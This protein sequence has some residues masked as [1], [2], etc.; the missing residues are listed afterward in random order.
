MTT[1]EIWDR[2][3]QFELKLRNIFTIV[4]NPVPI[5]EDDILRFSEDC[6]ELR[7]MIEDLEF[8]LNEFIGSK[9]YYDE[10]EKCEEMI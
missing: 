2:K 1:K 5:S 3:Q 10:I 7:D 9:D 8:T 6:Q 4:Q